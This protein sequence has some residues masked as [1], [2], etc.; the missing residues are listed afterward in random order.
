MLLAVPGPSLNTIEGFPGEA[1]AV[2]MFLR[3]LGRGDAC[4]HFDVFNKISPGRN[5]SVNT[6]E[7]AHL[8]ETLTVLTWTFRNFV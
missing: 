7:L 3:H 4:M 5:G 8:L 1:C 2:A 6:C